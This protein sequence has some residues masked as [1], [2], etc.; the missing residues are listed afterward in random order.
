MF[1]ISAAQKQYEIDV[2]AEIIAAFTEVITSEIDKEILSRLQ[3]KPLP[4]QLPRMP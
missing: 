2:E 4:N 1:K 3:R